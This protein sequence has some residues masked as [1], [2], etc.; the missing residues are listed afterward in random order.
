[1]VAS[2]A[3]G[4]DSVMFRMW[5]H[6]VSEIASSCFGG[7]FMLVRR[8]LFRM[9]LHAVA[10]VSSSYFVGGFMPFRKLFHAVSDVASWCFWC[11]VQFLV[12]ANGPNAT[13]HTQPANAPSARI[14]NETN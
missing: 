14:R 1:M 5:I 2:I 8:W 11:V 12:H 9:W 10:H 6:S 7:G 13:K 3:F 4:G